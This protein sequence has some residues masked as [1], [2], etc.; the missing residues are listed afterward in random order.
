[1]LCRKNQVDRRERFSPSPP[2]GETRAAWEAARGISAEPEAGGRASGRERVS[3]GVRASS[4]QPRNEA[5]IFYQLRV[6]ESCSIKIHNENN[7]QTSP[8]QAQSSLLKPIKAPPGGLSKMAHFAH[9]I[10][11]HKNYKT[12][13]MN[14]LNKNQIQN[15][16]LKTMSKNPR[17]RATKCAHNE[18]QTHQPLQS[19]ALW[20]RRHNSIENRSNRGLSMR[21]R[22]KCG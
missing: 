20:Q 1:M 11:L 8:I 6:R 7:R 21:L 4:F 14:N 12:F 9:R 13:V 2:S 3:A 10:C 5:L 16:T 17:F 18:T 19:F 22:L 15:P